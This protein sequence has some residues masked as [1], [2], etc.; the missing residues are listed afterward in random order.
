MRCEDCC[1]NNEK[2][3]NTPL[4][5]FPNPT[6]DFFEVKGAEN[7][8]GVIFAIDGRMM[9]HFDTR[10]PTDVSDLPKGMYIVQVG[11]EVKKLI[12]N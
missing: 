8:E 3:D 11:F 12:I 5:I 9:R 2:I 1:N 10:Q 4:R 6:S 7:R